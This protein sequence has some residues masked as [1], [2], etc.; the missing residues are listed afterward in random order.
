MCFASFICSNQFTLFLAV[1]SKD[2]FALGTLE[3]EG[4]H[5][6]LRSI[7]YVKHGSFVKWCNLECRMQ[8]GSRRPTDKERYADAGF[9]EGFRRVTHFV[10]RRRD[11]STQ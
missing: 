11:E 5:G 4:K 1:F 2:L 6:I 7:F 10:E 3:L 9:V 8:I